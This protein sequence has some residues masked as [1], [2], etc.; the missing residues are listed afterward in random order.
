MKFENGPLSRNKS[1]F[2]PLLN[3]AAYW[4]SNN[5]KACANKPP[6]I[7]ADNIDNG[8]RGDWPQNLCE[9]LSK[10][11]KLKIEESLE[12]FG[13][14]FSSTSLFLMFGI[15]Q[16]VLRLIGLLLDHFDSPKTEVSKLWGDIMNFYHYKS[17][18]SK[19]S[20]CFSFLACYNA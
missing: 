11:Y 15:Y 9:V 1:G 14:F 16:M 20:I 18:Y 17:K 19:Y 4:K 6:Q 7:H 5:S 3:V 2:F 12:K 8:R 10:K 13:I